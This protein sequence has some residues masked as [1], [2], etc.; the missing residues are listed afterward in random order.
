MEKGLCVHPVRFQSPKEFPRLALSRL[1]SHLLLL[2]FGGLLRRLIAFLSTTEHVIRDLVEQDMT[3]FL[4]AKGP[5]IR[6]SI[7]ARQSFQAWQGLNAHPKSGGRPARFPLVEPMSFDDDGVAIP[8]TDKV[9]DHM[10]LR[11]ATVE[12]AR[13]LTPSRC[14]RSI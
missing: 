14:G 7:D 2:C 13:L 12:H 3:S 4:D 9:A 8:T 6:V 5:D 1:P 10:H 11:F